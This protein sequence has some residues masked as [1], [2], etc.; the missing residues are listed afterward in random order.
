M[1]DTKA[2]AA[3]ILEILKAEDGQEFKANWTGAW[4]RNRSK[5]AR[6]EGESVA[7]D[8]NGGTAVYHPPFTIEAMPTP[9][10]M[11]LFHCKDA[12][13]TFESKVEEYIP[14]E[15]M[16]SFKRELEKECERLLNTGALDLDG[17]QGIGDAVISKV[18][19]AT[20][21]YNLSEDLSG[22]MQRIGLNDDIQN[23]RKF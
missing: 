22:Q 16:D 5:N 4:D 1:K 15:H 21:M 6:M 14:K 9:T 23:L 18:V 3:K 12:D 20:A 2:T 17:L 19:M 8:F 11:F 10:E 7:V 13:F